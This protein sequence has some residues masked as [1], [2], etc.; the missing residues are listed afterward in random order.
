MNSKTCESTLAWSK[1][2]FE[3][4]RGIAFD[5]LSLYNCSEKRTWSAW[6]EGSNLVQGITVHQDNA[7]VKLV[8]PWGQTNNL[9]TESD[10]EISFYAM[11]GPL[12]CCAL[13]VASLA[14]VFTRRNRKRVFGDHNIS[15]AEHPRTPLSAKIAV[16]II[17]YA[18]I[19]L[20][21]FSNA[22]IGA[23]VTAGVQM[24]DKELVEVS[25]FDFSL[26]NTI[27]DMWQAGVYPLSILVAIWSGFW[28]YLKC[29]LML[30]AWFLPPKMLS[31]AHRRR[32]LISLDILGKWALLG[33][34]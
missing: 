4:E 5:Y 23:T 2:V 24:F 34:L 14:F 26:L 6:S 28:P 19:G 27:T 1:P 20:F 31:A 3:E 18:T 17:L 32:L 9:A 10:G 21:S 12:I 8:L 29:F 30:T 15:L 11:L 7:D 22:S 13:C 33:K 25:L 16:P